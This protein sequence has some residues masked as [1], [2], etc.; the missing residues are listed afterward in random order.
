MD[1]KE[2]LEEI[3]MVE[4]WEK[5]EANKIDEEILKEMT[6]DD[7]KD[8]GIDALGDRKTLMSA[9]EDINEEESR[10]KRRVE[11]GIQEK[12]WSLKNIFIW[13]MIGLFLGV[14][15]VMLGGPPAP[16]LIVY[17]S[18]SLVVWIKYSR[19]RSC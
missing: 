7:L 18:F 9:I 10:R 3:G 15:I 8:I 11:R 16:V 2:W 13:K 5:F 6:E 4:H 19:V 14:V 17:F 12:K 1:I